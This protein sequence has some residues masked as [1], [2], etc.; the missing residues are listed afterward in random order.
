MEGIKEIEGSLPC[1]GVN[2]KTMKK[3]KT[4]QRYAQVLRFG[5]KQEADLVVM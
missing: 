4:E 5:N 3:I 1:H 2:K